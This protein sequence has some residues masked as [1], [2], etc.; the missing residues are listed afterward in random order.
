MASTKIALEKQRAQSVWGASP[1][2]QSLAPELRPGTRA[3]FESTRR[4][5][6]EYELRT[7][8]ALI[9]FHEFAGKRV[10]EIGCGAGYD[11]ME[12]QLA[13]A[14]YFGIDLTYENTLRT[15][16][17]LG[18]YGYSPN[19]GQGDAESLSFPDGSFDVVFSNGVLH[20]TPDIGGSLAEAYRVLRP[21]G[22]LWLT[23]YNRH[24]VFYL[25][26]LYLCRYLLK[27][28][29]RQGTFAKMVAKI[30]YTT[31]G[32]LP[33]VNAYSP[34]ECAALLRRAGFAVRAIRVRKLNREDLPAAR[35]LTFFWN[36]IPQR[37]LDF[38]GRLLGW[39]IVAEAVRQN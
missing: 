26:T 39:Y 16:A 22:T 8:L 37:V 7:V 15:R 35:I 1:A 23:V 11:A 24:S 38:L 31:S 29:Y 6:G 4:R 13:G 2:G 19:V 28:E 30:E 27:R 18:F 12:F 10:L 14:D 21:G 9:P 32:T 17:H 33:L 5:R 20:H 36:L 25:F 34:R 3:Y